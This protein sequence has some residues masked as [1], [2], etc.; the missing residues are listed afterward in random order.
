MEQLALNTCLPARAVSE[1]SGP[2]VAGDGV[3]RGVGVSSGG[4][5]SLPQPMT[6]INMR[7]TTM[8]KAARPTYSC[9]FV[10][11]IRVSLRIDRHGG[12]EEG[13]RP[14]VWFSENPSYAVQCKLITRPSLSKPRSVR[15]GML[16]FDRKG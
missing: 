15:R 14:A 8:P 12:T 3:A 11:H 1:S 16:N 2:G 6:A 13:M 9:A 5:G 7:V 4:S 10:S